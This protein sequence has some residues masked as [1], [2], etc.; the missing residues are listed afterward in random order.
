MRTGAAPTGTSSI[1][2]APRQR[3]TTPRRHSTDTRRRVRTRVRR[4][5]CHSS[6]LARAIRSSPTRPQRPG[7]PS[8]RLQYD[9]PVG[10]ISEQS[11][12]RHQKARSPRRAHERS[13]L[14]LPRQHWAKCHRR[15]GQCHAGQCEPPA[16]YEPGS[17]CKMGEQRYRR[18]ERS[19]PPASAERATGS[20]QPTRD[21]RCS[22]RPADPRQRFLSSLRRWVPSVTGYGPR[23]SKNTSLCPVT[24]H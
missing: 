7:Q 5:P 10:K 23:S 2:W 13:C 1:K 14:A 3:S 9:R 16:H 22:R 15:G 11:Y 17:A 21:R 18:H 24:G 19:V 6:C 20:C 12:T 8:P 4:A